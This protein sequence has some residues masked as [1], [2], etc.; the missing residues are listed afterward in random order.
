MIQF[1]RTILAAGLLVA[2][3]LAAPV[4][5]AQTPDATDSA[6]ADV[7]VLIHFRMGTIDGDDRTVTKSYTLIVASGSSGSSLL[8]GQRVP[9]PTVDSGFSR[10]S[11]DDSTP[12]RAIVYQ[13][14]GFATNAEA[15]VIGGNKI[16]LR[17]DIENSRIVEDED[18]GLPIVETRQLTINAILTDGQPLDVTR[19]EGLM[20]RPGFVEVEARILR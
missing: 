12:A 8:A 10:G 16:R 1:E 3:L 11:V 15:M 18:G 6:A 9:F 2:V 17:A 13:N 7:N 19:A 14:I 4:A 5:V 20:D